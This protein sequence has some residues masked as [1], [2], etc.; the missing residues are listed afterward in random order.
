VP[1]PTPYVMDIHTVYS[2]EVIDTRLSLAILLIDEFTGQQPRGNAD[3]IVEKD[4]HPTRNL[5]GYYLFSALS[6]GNHEVSAESSL[7]FSRKEMI[8]TSVLDPKN[9]VVQITLMPNPSYPFPDNATL[10]RG[11][12]RDTA[13]IASAEIRATGQT[14]HSFTDAKG[15]FVLF[16]KGIKKDDI[17]L[18]I[19]KNGNT[20]VRMITIMEGRTSSAGVIQFP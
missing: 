9:P 11:L 18:E 1:K 10:I 14:A 13:P 17:A 5:S 7:Y 20:E 6:A 2:E 19:T 16:F 8:D 15:E 3:V 4:I 12:V